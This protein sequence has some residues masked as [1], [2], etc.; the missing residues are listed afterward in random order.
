LIVWYF[1]L[2]CY[3]L[4]SV[5]KALTLVVFLLESLVQ[6]CSIIFYTVFLASELEGGSIPHPYVIK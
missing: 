2:L 6:Y 5:N 4:T 3:S 1:F